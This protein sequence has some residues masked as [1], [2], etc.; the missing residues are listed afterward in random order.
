VVTALGLGLVAVGQVLLSS[1][2]VDGSYARD[3]LPGLALFGLGLGTSFVGATI[4]ATEG[5]PPTA[6]GLAS[7]LVS[8]AQQVGMAIGVAVAVSVATATTA[9]RFD[10]A[11]A[12]AL[13]AGYERGLLF[14][15]FVAAAGVGAALLIRTDRGSHTLTDATRNRYGPSSTG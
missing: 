7:G 5:L 15:A 4:M 11:S 14:G 10:P 8:T 9:S 2:P 6:R 3:L 13:V 1:I 12:S